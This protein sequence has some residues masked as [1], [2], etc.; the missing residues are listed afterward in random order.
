L[1]L[2]FRDRIGLEALEATMDGGFSAKTSI[3]GASFKPSG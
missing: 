2:S 3:S 1:A